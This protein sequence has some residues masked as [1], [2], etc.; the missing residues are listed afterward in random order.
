MDK[1]IKK[2][3]DNTATDAE[4]A[5]LIEGKQYQKELITSA[6]SLR[7]EV[8]SKSVY[9]RGL[10]EFTNYCKNDCLYCGIRR[11]NRKATRY[12]LTKEEILACCE[13]GYVLGFRT[14][15]L[16]GGEDPFFTT[17]VLCDIVS[18]IRKRYPDCA[19]TL[20]VGEKSREDYHA[21]RRSGADRYLLRHE[22]ATLSHYE[23]L[24]TESQN[25]ENRKR[26]LYE[27]KA[28][29]FQVGSGFMVGSP[30][31]RT[32]HLV[33][34]LR[35]LQELQPDMI[36]IGPFISHAET[37]FADFPNG[38]LDLCLRIIAILRLMFPFALIPSTTAMG[39]LCPEGRLLGLAAG[40]NVVMPNLS[41]VRVRD[42]Y[43]LY[44]NK[45]YI[46]AESAQGLAELEKE[47]ERIGCRIISSRGDAPK[48]NTLFPPFRTT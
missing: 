43:K 37:P 1:T 35:F 47:V 7:R 29:G 17:P 48:R 34:D 14:F 24:H 6:D 20:S 19:I 18:E 28:E 27:L 33:N 4:L 40:A 16:Q 21:L 5:E 32:E 36:G 30:Y 13:S 3:A 23:K 41:P 31:Q 9:I 15:V 26:C 11:S 2:I 38:N 22:T 12:R 8:F 45:A 46:G 42:F 10:I 25:L 39:T 44:D